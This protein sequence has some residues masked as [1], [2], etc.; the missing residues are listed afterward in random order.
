M[1]NNF[2]TGFDKPK[3]RA[4]SPAL[5]AHAAWGW[6]AYDERNKDPFPYIFQLASATIL[7][8]YSKVTDERQSLISPALTGVFGAWAFAIMKPSAWP[9]GTISAGAT[10]TKFTLT[11]ALPASV[12]VNQIANRWDGIW[13]RVRIIDNG[14]WGSGK[15]AERRVIANT[16]WT[17]PTIVVDEALGFTPVSWSTYEF[18]SPRIYML[19]SG[20]LAAWSWKYYDVLTNSLSWNLSITNLPATVSTDTAWIVTDERYVPYS[21][22]GW[23]W[24]LVDDIKVY[25]S[26]SITYQKACLQ[27]TAIA[28]WSIT[29]MASAW[30]FAVLADEYK[31]FCQIRIVEDTVNPTA[32]GQRRRITSHTAWPSAV[33]TLASNWAV[34][35]SANCK[36]VIENNNDIMHLWST[37]TTA[38][39]TY[40]I[41]GNAWDT[42]TI[43]ARG[44][45]IGAGVWAEHA[46]SIVPDWEKNSRQS[47]VFS[48]RWW[49]FATIDVL[50]LSTRTW[51]NNIDYGNKG[52]TL[53]TTGTCSCKDPAT[54]LWRYIYIGLNGTVRNQRFNMF[55]RTL[56]P[57]TTLRQTPGATLAWSR[58][59]YTSKT[60]PTTGDKVSSIMQILPTSATFYQLDILFELASENE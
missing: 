47:F 37:A 36:F 27:A 14:A 33:Y 43:P 51:S 45:V 6:I 44:G 56:E 8:A 18:V 35:P 55:S 24:F 40:N 50:D 3:W 23:E 28:V 7:N 30:D 58:F 39:Y 53:F 57:N 31:N 5:T 48:G 1:E 49:N 15:I 16:A 52:L 32:V 9:T 4:N 54:N 2:I 60:D 17:T 59:A 38:C 22:K 42:T 46:F 26:A 25:D 10:T 19:S 20:L 11:T 41:T 34:T 13:F 29:G 21:R 12:W